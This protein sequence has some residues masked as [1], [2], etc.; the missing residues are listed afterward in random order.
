MTTLISNLKIYELSHQKNIRDLGGLKG[1][2]G[3]TIKY[4]RIYRGGALNKV[5]EEDV[6]VLE[7]FHLTDIID[8]R[9][10]IE[11]LHHPDHKFENVRYHNFTTFDHEMKN[12]EARHDDGN[13]LWFMNNGD[14][15]F[16]HL[17]RTYRELVD[18]EEGQAAY[19]NLFKVLMSEGKPVV[20][21]HCSQGKDRVGIGAFLIEAALGVDMETMKE[22]YLLS[23]VA[24]EKR[25]GALIDMVK[26]LPFFN[27]QY[28]KD[29][30]EVF[31]AKLEYLNEAINLLNAKY[32]GVLPYIENVLNVDIKK[33][34]EL[35]LE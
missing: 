16:M 7:S 26:D 25:R 32:G 2:D 30:V 17:S 35:Y 29:L 18:T 6:K 28:E 24:M 22:D 4:G 12:E 1:A 15:G 23:N 14:T 11:F 8:F 9:S 5:N 34:R 33:F 3:K 21:F 31:S 13:L 20:Y 27:E 19:R 10:K